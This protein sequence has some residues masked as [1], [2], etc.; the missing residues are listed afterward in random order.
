M[1]SLKGRESNDTHQIPRQIVPASYIHF[2][3]ECDQL[4]PIFW[5][6]VDY[7]LPG[8]SVHETFQARTLEWAAIS[9]SKGILLTQG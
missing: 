3:C 8:S 4:R 7:N 5:D 1:L 9:S 2:A 6:P